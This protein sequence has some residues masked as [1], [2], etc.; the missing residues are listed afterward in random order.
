M[1]T[2][3]SSIESSSAA[4]SE[5]GLA[6]SAG[7][8]HKRG[9]LAAFF[10]I[11]M[12]QIEGWLNKR[13]FLKTLLFAVLLSFFFQYP[14]FVEIDSAPA[15]KGLIEISH[16]IFEQIEYPDGS[17]L[18]KKTVRLT[19]P[20]ITRF[21]GIESPYGLYGLFVISNILLLA[22]SYFYLRDTVKDKISVFFLV[23]SVSCIYPGC[24]G[25]NDV[26]GLADIVPYTLLSICL[27]FP[28]AWVW[29]LC[30]SA[31]LLA[32]ERS[33]MGGGILLINSC[34]FSNI[35]RP[36]V[37]K[38]RFVDKRLYSMIFAIMLFVGFRLAL[39]EVFDFSIPLGAVG[40]AEIK[41][42][43]SD[44]YFLGIWSAFE[45]YWLVIGLFILIRAYQKRFS[46]AIILLLYTSA[47]IF[48][49][50]CVH[51]L[52]KSIAYLFPLCLISIAVVLNDLN[53][54][55][56]KRVLVCF[57]SGFCILNPTQFVFGT[58]YLYPSVI[59]R[60]L[61]EFSLWF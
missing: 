6:P 8:I 13:T 14:H 40:L 48:A 36:L 49:S 31:A 37:F 47:A 32:D 33:L 60:V 15:M 53:R 59:N 21:L 41:H 11:A 50:L 57:V 26:K 39:I 44:F 43:Q 29:F 61:Q 45:A 35:G 9:R 7:E 28:R 18:E 38:L 16:S 27:A 54:T 58:G 24:C 42:I 22:A 34:L 52:T 51:D 12:D 19:V 56:S 5:R 17:H 1:Q 4:V 30:F 23:C 25:F 46:S 3:L 55:T 20:A 2:P 10:S